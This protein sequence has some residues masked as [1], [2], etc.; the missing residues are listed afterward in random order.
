[1]FEWIASDPPRRITALPCAQTERERVGRHVGTRLVDDR[2]D[3]ERDAHAR[4]LQPVRTAHERSHRADRIGQQGDALDRRGD[5][6]EAGPVEAQA[7]DHRRR[8]AGALGGL[9]I[10][11]VRVDD[12]RGALTDPHGDLTERTL[13]H[14]SRRLRDRSRGRLCVPRDPFHAVSQ[15]VDAAIS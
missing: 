10:G 12:A 14:A 6:L 7:I 4:H 13:S 9:E 5:L 11:A 3:A 15:L 8:D 1:V 2:D